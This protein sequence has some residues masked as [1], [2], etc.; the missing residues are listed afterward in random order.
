M[1]VAQFCKRMAY[2]KISPFAPAVYGKNSAILIL[3]VVLFV[4][5]FREMNKGVWENGLVK[6]WSNSS[7]FIILVW[8]PCSGLVNLLNVF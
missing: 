8:D 1:F 5:Y 2:L 3:E 4:L 7:Q 6:L